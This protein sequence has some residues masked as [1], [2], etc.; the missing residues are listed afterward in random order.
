MKNVGVGNGTIS[1][2]LRM[3]EKMDII[4]SRK[5]GLRYRAFYISQGKLP[6]KEKKRLTSLQSKILDLVK[7]NDGIAQTELTKILGEKQQTVS[8]N[9][10]KLERSGF[11]RVDK[12]DGKSYCYFA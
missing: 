7:K 5:K 1:H 10:K 6:E 9:V 8:Y 3:L 11:I 12:K 4:K 2:H